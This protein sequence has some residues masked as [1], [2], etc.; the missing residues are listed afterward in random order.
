MMRCGEK[1]RMCS[2]GRVH[3]HYRREKEREKDDVG[4]RRGRKDVGEDRRR[5][6]PLSIILH[7][8]S[9]IRHLPG[10]TVVTSLVTPTPS[11]LVAP[12]PPFPVGY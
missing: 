5:G 12:T 1:E 11:P 6:N 2:R 3:R 9:P 7:F 4:E 8:Q 10:R